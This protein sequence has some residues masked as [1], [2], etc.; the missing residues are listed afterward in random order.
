M[1]S[2][3]SKNNTVLFWSLGGM[4]LMLNFEGAIAKALMLRGYGAHA[5]LCDGSFRACIKRDIKENSPI[6]QWAE[7]CPKCKRD[8]ANVLEAIGVPF[9]FIGEFVPE[10]AR[11]ELWDET[12]GIT[13][14]SLERLGFK[15]IFVGKSAQSAITRYL[16]GSQLAGREEI[17]HEYAYSALICAAAAENIFKKFMPAKIFMSTGTY[18]DYGP[19]L[20]TALRM[21]IPACAWM[22]SY[23]AARFYFRHIE[24]NMRIDFHNI[25]HAAWEN[26]RKLQID[27][28]KELRLNEFFANRYKDNISFDMKK[29][30]SYSGDALGLRKRYAPSLDKPAWG[31]LAHINWDSVSDYSPMAYSS[32]DAWILE[33]IKIVSQITDIQWIIKIHPAESWDNPYSGVRKLIERHYPSLPSHIRVIPSEEKIS[34]LDFLQMI[35]GGVTVYGTAGLE[36]LLQGKPVI[37][38]GEAHYGGKGFTYDGLTPESYAQLLQKAR[39]LLAPDHEKQLLAKKYAYCYFIQRQIPFPALW[40][41]NTDWW[42]YQPRN[43]AL[44]LPRKEPFADFICERIVDGKDFIMTEDLVSKAH[45]AYSKG[46]IGRTRSFLS[47]I[48]KRGMEEAVNMLNRIKRKV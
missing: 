6:C 41:P 30:H 44:L 43:E 39:T 45:K 37:L 22:A 47:K 40:D 42:N 17:V 9:S 20:H 12:E 11:L 32:F 8:A 21:E 16:Q 1:I 7:V 14:D 5:I 46:F 33:T 10:K 28:A 27:R 15:G 36:L 18:V 2:E 26:C 19:A 25:S 29:F 48:R 23:L 4:P 24:D 31:I 34:P 38:A 35:D 13:W 3:S